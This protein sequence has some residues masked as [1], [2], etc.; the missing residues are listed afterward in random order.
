[1]DFCGVAVGRSEADIGLEGDRDPFERDGLDDGTR[2][3][4]EQLRERRRQVLLTGHFTEGA[5]KH[6]GGEN[7][8]IG[9]VRDETV[10]PE[11]EIEA[12]QKSA[13]DGNTD[14]RESVDNTEPNAAGGV[15][16]DEFVRAD[17]DT[18]DNKAPVA[19]AAEAADEVENSET[20]LVE[21]PMTDRAH[22]VGTDTVNESGGEENVGTTE[23]TENVAKEKTE[24]QF[25][26][27]VDLAEG[28]DEKA[29]DR[30]EE[31]DEKTE[32]R[33]EGEE[34]KTEDRSEVGEEKTE[35][36]VEEGDVK[37]NVE[38]SAAGADESD[39]ESRRTRV[40]LDT[41]ALDDPTG[42]PGAEEDK[43]TEQGTT[44]ENNA[45]NVD[46]ENTDD[47]PDVNGGTETDATDEVG[48]G[49]TTKEVEE[50]RGAE[51]EQAEKTE[52]EE[53]EHRAGAG[54]ETTDKTEG[55]STE[56]TGEGGERD[57]T[58]GEKTDET[59][60]EGREENVEEGGEHGVEEEKAD[61][62]ED[63]G[64]EVPVEEEDMG[65]NNPDR[66]DIKGG[67]ELNPRRDLSP[68]EEK[69]YTAND[70]YDDKGRQLREDEEVYEHGHHER[71]A[72]S[73]DETTQNEKQPEPDHYAESRSIA[74]KP[75]LSCNGRIV[76]PSKYFDLLTTFLTM[77]KKFASYETHFPPFPALCLSISPIVSVEPGNLRSSLLSSIGDDAFRLLKA[78]VDVDN[79]VVYIHGVDFPPNGEISCKFSNI[80]RGFLLAIRGKYVS[81]NLVT[82]PIPSEED[83]RTEDIA[84]GQSI[85]ISVS[86]KRIKG[87]TN[88]E[89]QTVMAKGRNRSSIIDRTY[90]LPAEREC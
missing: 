2:L 8:G 19:A 75:N 77:Q 55:D 38:E 59:E 23:T 26:G 18:D 21:P 69:D 76:K 25:E 13:G 62:S 6:E 14:T 66:N 79:N 34:E 10:E 64:T 36:R 72:G 52:G 12:G 1:M 51:E 80:N 5:D 29:E 39:L 54:E 70:G 61:K 56:G 16:T 24:D 81:G 63:G 44:D 22:Q 37:T 45:H 4:R 71:N 68:E 84:N 49:G 46:T 7:E 40:E 85:L 60:G 82:C 42:L 50:G 20:T 15:E 88:A 17:A 41:Q 83:L 43:R 35:E 30:V 47:K 32:D 27:R 11:G 57:G 31:G 3:E 48:G 65:G 89:T 58:E 90:S 86:R 67:D 28:G 87:R 9:V 74:P 73:E 53:G 78:Q 33:F